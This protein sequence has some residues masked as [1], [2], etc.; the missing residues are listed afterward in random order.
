MVA[1]L[2]GHAAWA[3][4]HFGDAQSGHK[5]R[6]QR[7]VRLAAQSAADPSASLPEATGRWA[8]LKAAY[9]LFDDDQVGFQAIAEPHRRR[10]RQGHP[11]AALILD[12][13]TEMDS[14]AARRI[15]GVGP[16]GSGIGQGSLLH[17]ALLAPLALDRRPSG[18]EE[19]SSHTLFM[20]ANVH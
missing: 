9:R 2:M 5:R 7:L 14:G 18:A 4:A 20:R 1:A 19:I 17:S 12:D 6:N 8:H 16:V 13:T 3:L 15:R 11:E 10:T